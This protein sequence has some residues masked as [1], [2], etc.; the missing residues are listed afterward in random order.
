[1]TGD[2][3]FICPG[4]AGGFILVIGMTLASCTARDGE[5]RLAVTIEEGVPHV[6]SPEI[7]YWGFAARP[8]EQVEVL[9]ADDSAGQ[10]IFTRPLTVAVNSDGIRHILDQRACC[11]WRVAAD[12]SSLDP[13]GRQGEGPGEFN[14]P[15]DMILLPDD[16][17]VVSDIGNLR[18][19]F[20]SAN[21]TFRH[22]TSF[23]DWIGQFE[24]AG[25]DRFFAYRRDRTTTPRAL[26]V[27]MDP[28]NP[29]LRLVDRA[30]ETVSSFGR[31]QVVIG[32]APD[33]Y[34]NKLFLA[35]L[36]GDSL[37]VSYQGVDRIEVFTGAG[38]LARVIHRPVP[39]ATTAPVYEEQSRGE[40]LQPFVG[41]GF[42]ILGSGLGVHP[43]GG[44]L[45]VLVPQS[46]ARERTPLIGEAEIP[47]LWA[48]DL[49]DRT[50]RWLARQPLAITCPRALLDWGPD[51]LYL[52]NL[53]G[54]AAVYRFAFEP[55]TG[56]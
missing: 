41:W 34:I 18:L 56:P 52:I 53:E 55:A 26:G 10:P 40:G 48:L 9:G 11:I 28:A 50:G 31:R 33:V 36:P 6:R 16:S 3:R 42:D 4:I 21:G 2:T 46:R 14:R 8:F 32:Q 15:V 54:D 47:D 7:P 17:L 1:M 22:S 23:V 43:E 38:T 51:G 12:G 44:Y 20:F 39:F 13:I 27:E 29:Q 25:E 30:A 49:F 45:A 37:A 19:S 24:P 35:S 5:W